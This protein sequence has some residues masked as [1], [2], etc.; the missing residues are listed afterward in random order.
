MFPF[1]QRVD[2]ITH[3]QQG[4]MLSFAPGRL[5]QAI[6]FH[7]IDEGR[8]RS[9]EAEPCNTSDWMAFSRMAP[10]IIAKEKWIAMTNEQRLEWL[11]KR[12]RIRIRAGCDGSSIV[13]C[14]R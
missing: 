8:A 13:L 12:S 3:E 2:R 14:I 11:L 6:V 4:D 9:V 1:S 7:L 10:A 5:V